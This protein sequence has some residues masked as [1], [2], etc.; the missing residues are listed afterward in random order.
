MEWSEIVQTSLCWATDHLPKLDS[1]KYN[2]G[3]ISNFVMQ[4]IKQLEKASY[5]SC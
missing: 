5:T 2:L 1:P 4:G 3:F